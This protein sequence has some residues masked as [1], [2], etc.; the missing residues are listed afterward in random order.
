MDDL[1]RDVAAT[2]RG[3]QMPFSSNRPAA[4]RA[5]R[6]TALVFAFSLVLAATAFAGERIPFKGNAA[7]QAAAKAAVVQRSDLGAGWTGGATKPDLSSDT[8]CAGWT[9][10]QSDLVMTGAA[11]ST[12]TAKG[13]QISSEV[14][15]L[16]STKMVRLDW[17]RTAIDPRALGCVREGLAKALNNATRKLISV[18]RLSFPRLTA[19]T[20][21]FRAL[22]DVKSNGSTLRLISD[23]VV[24]GKGRNELTLLATA[25]Y[26]SRTPVKAIEIQL[27]RLL[28]SRLPA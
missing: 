4:A 23:I 24:V 5:A 12:F 14:N 25:S 16:Q 13:L 27:A 11:A 17:Q 6:S 28:T 10:K 26:A 9:P 20:L 2:F 18:N 7:D 22:V 8:G 15:V 19:Q 21:A 3:I 1:D